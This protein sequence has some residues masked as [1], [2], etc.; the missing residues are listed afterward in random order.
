MICRCGF[1]SFWAPGFGPSNYLFGGF[2][3]VCFCVWKVF[4]RSIWSMIGWIGRDDLVDRPPAGTCDD[5]VDRRRGGTTFV[6]MGCYMAGRSRWRLGRRCWL[7]G[8]S[9]WHA[10]HCNFGKFF[11]RAGL[12]AFFWE[13]ARRAYLR[14]TAAVAGYQELFLRC[15]SFSEWS[16]SS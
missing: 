1:V 9:R 2:S 12:I 7:P 16:S 10:F 8:R 6:F 11:R 15:F 5:L 13:L 4:G 14:A 3:L